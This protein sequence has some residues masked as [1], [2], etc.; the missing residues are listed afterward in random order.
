MRHG[1]C[2]SKQRSLSALSTVS[3]NTVFNNGTGISAGGSTLVE[4]N[5]VYGQSGDGIYIGNSVYNVLANT[6]HDNNLGIYSY[7]TATIQNNLVYHNT[8]DGLEPERSSTVTGN[9]VYGN[10]TGIALDY[11]SVSPVSNNL[12]YSNTNLG[13]LE[14]YGSSAP[15]INNTVYQ[16]GG[17]AVNI[18]DSSVNV[19]LRNNILWVQSPATAA[20]D[21]NI[22]PTS[23]QGFQSDYNDLCA[24]GAGMIA[25]LQGQAFSSQQLWF[26]ASGQ[27]QHSL[28]VDPQFIAPAGPDGILGFSA[29]TIGN[30]QVIDDAGSSGFSTTGTWTKA[31]VSSADNGE[32]VTAPSGSGTS[33]ATWNFTGL[34]PGATYRVSVSWSQSSSLASDAPFSV[35]DG[36]QLISFTYQNE[37]NAPS[38]SGTP[39]FQSLG[40]FITTTGSITVTLNN[41]SSGTVAADAAMVQQVVGN[42]GADDNFLV[43]AGSP[44]I[45]AGSPSDPFLLEPGVNGYRINLGNYGNTAQATPDSAA[46]TLQVLTPGPLDKLQTGQNVNIT[47]QTSGLYAPAN[48][49]S[50]AVLA[51]QPLAYYRLDDASGTVAADA[52]G[53]GLNATYVGGVQL[54]QVGALPF[55]TDTA[56]TLDGSTGYVQLPTISNSFNSGFSAEIWA[57][58][59]SVASNQRFFD[60]GN[61]TYSDNIVLFRIGTTNNLGFQVYSGGASGAV[62][63]AQNAISLN[64]WQYFAVTMDSHGNVALYRNGVAIA[65]GTTSLPRAGITRTKNY[66][67]KSNFGDPLYAGSFDEAAIYAAPLSAAQIAAHYAQ[68][69][70]GTVNIDLLQ[71]GTVVQNIA[72][73]AGDSDSFAWT[74]PASAAFGSGYQIRVTANIGIGPSGTSAQQ[75]LIANNGHSYYVNDG[76]TT[77]DVYTTAAGNDA[78]SGKDPAHPM[79]TLAAVLQAYTL[80]SADTVYVDTG[81]YLVL[82]NIFLDPAHSGVSI[83]GPTSGPARWSIAAIPTQASTISN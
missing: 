30:A 52:S 42:R 44:S 15:L 53:S 43:A 80:G 81:N 72:T 62:V 25:D 21:I 59:T 69:S 50:G 48:Y 19:V 18:Q 41:A 14:Y 73:G 58:P 65:A 60:L 20:Y 13:V 12:V 4:N 56:V 77:G 22:D 38:Q 37:R 49:Y 75:F 83:V 74:V 28:A 66:I 76:S 16:P 45:D 47:W 78:N 61:G 17:D 1:H 55:D 79:A 51:N 11:Y 34:T 82:H 54:G 46:Q 70:Y 7:G 6:V 64:Q 31:N 33:V 27:D 36:T 2:H 39:A 8:T 35:Y 9:T 67:G 3:G 24:T 57:D 40:Y 23:E 5:N 29:A 26:Y 32:Y 10:A 68:R 63:T 71:N